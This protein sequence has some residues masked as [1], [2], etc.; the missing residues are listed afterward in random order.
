MKN[1]ILIILS[2]LALNLKSQVA[3]KDS[4]YLIRHTSVYSSTNMQTG[5]TRGSTNVKY[6]YKLGANGSFVTVKGN[7]YKNIVDV[8][9]ESA[10]KYKQCT[11]SAKQATL[12][13]G[14]AIGLAGTFIAGVIIGG[15]N[16]RK[17][18]VKGFTWLGIGAISLAGVYILPH[19]SRKKAYDALRYFEESADVY[20]QYVKK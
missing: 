2:L 1:L 18:P 15:K 17:E 8:F 7:N 4:L 19:K 14:I 16:F 6:T 9:P 5:A 10:K 20:N 13:G 3:G 11:S 12:L